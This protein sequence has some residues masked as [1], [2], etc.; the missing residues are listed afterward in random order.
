MVSGLKHVLVVWPYN[1][2][3]SKHHDLEI[4]PG[5]IPAQDLPEMIAIDPQ[6]HETQD[7][8]AV[9]ISVV[10]SLDSGMLVMGV[11]NM[12]N[13]QERMDHFDRLTR[14]TDLVD[15]PKDLNVDVK[16]AWPRDTKNMESNE[17]HISLG[18]DHCHHL[19]QGEGFAR[20]YEASHH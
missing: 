13:I 1:E 7:E 20:L 17:N 4:V 14:K 2:N 12:D 15:P 8:G 6:K 5:R 11:L 16:K 10:C 18:Y 9:E 19:A 3:T